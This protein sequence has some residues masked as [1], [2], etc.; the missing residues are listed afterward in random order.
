ML[1]TEEFVEGMAAA[2]SG[3]RTVLDEIE[4]ALQKRQYKEITDGL[5]HLV[6]HSINWQSVWIA[7]LTYEKAEQEKRKESSLSQGGQH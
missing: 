2:L 7:R 5:A 6:G 1:Y 4:R 3:A